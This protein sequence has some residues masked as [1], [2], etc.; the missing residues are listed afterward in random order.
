MLSFILKTAVRNLVLSEKI[1]LFLLVTDAGGLLV[2]SSLFPQHILPMPQ[3]K[4]DYQRPLWRTIPAQTFSAFLWQRGA[5]NSPNFFN[6]TLRSLSGL[7]RCWL[8]VWPVDLLCMCL[9]KYFVA[10]CLL[11]LKFFF[12]F[13]YDIY[14]S[15]ATI[16]LFYLTEIWN[17]SFRET[18]PFIT[19]SSQT[20]QNW[21][22]QFC[23]H[24][25]SNCVL[26]VQW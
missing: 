17:A 20:E 2:G 9:H 19:S 15:P 16:W 3:Y 18:S 10:F 26:Y 21:W 4:M 23:S 11:F 8:S 13:L 6:E 24:R 1:M 25:G 5:K 14:V 22:I 12:I 7:F